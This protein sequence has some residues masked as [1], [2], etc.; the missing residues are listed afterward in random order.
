MKKLEHVGQYLVSRKVKSFFQTAYPNHHTKS[1][2]FSLVELMVAISII[3]LVFGIII[4]S[5][6][7][8]QIRSRDTKRATDI[9][10][11]QNAL[12][13]YY[14]DQ[15]YFPETFSLS[16]ATS[17]TSDTGNPSTSKPVPFKTYSSSSGFP[18]DPTGGTYPQYCYLAYTDP[19][20]GT[21]GC[22][23]ADLSITTCQ[24]YRLFAQLESKANVPGPTCGTF[25]SYNTITYP[26]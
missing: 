11:I 13:Q 3:A 2:G 16:G 15:N 17:I 7:A 12:Q 6:R 23:N 24:Y 5:A 20:M 22:S 8:V 1:K 21:G 18:K 9:K 4:S 19:T 14:S 25:S 10:L 26:N